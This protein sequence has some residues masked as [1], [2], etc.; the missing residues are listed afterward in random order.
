LRE[1]ICAVCCGTE[2]EVTV[3]CPFDCGYLKESRRYDW[4]KSGVSAPLPFPEIKVGEGFLAEHEQFIGEIGLMLLRYAL[5]N[6]KTTDRD[7]EGALGSMIRTYETLSSGI[8]YE[9]QPEESSQIGV[10]RALKSFLQEYQ[11][12]ARKGEGLA[13]LKES[14]VIHSLVFVD[15]LAAAHSNKRPR[16]RGFIDFL[17]NAYPDATASKKEE[18]SLII[19][20]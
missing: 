13:G 4:V 6:P 16:S 7:I 17:R 9:S 2:R 18:S 14:E 8:Y 20:G 10:F 5:E 15:R 19:P 11:E 1:Y 3:D 12:K